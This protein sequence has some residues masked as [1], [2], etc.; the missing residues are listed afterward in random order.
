MNGEH[1]SAPQLCILLT[2]RGY[3][4]SSTQAISCYRAVKC[5]AQMSRHQAPT[6]TPPCDISP[7]ARILHEDF[8]MSQGGGRCS[9]RRKSALGTRS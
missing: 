6:S 7:D 2:Y 5:Q 4:G 3:S 9:R 1:E 8:R